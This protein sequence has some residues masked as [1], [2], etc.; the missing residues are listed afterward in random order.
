MGKTNFIILFFILTLST[1][2][3]SV[4]GLLK[5]P[6]DINDRSPIL[7]SDLLTSL[8]W[9]SL[10]KFS[11]TH[12]GHYTSIIKDSLLIK[13]EYI[14]QGR[15]TWFELESYKNMVLQFNC[16]ISNTSKPIN[17]DYFDKNVW[18]E[19]V[20]AMLPKLPEHFQLNANEPKEILK[21]YYRL[22]GA[23]KRDE[24]GW[25]CEYSTVGE[26]PGKRQAVIELLGR[27]DLL[28]KLFDYPNLQ[29]QLYAADALIFD[30]Y[31]TQRMIEKENAAN[32]KINI[33][34]LNSQLMTKSEWQK[35][36]KL[37]DSNQLVK[38]CGNMG[39]YKT[40]EATTSELLSEKSI[41]EIPEQYKMLKELGYFRDSFNNE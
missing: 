31:R 23:N 15:V 8:N 19:Y 25:I 11:T 14:E 1:N 33:E 26:A 7:T 2:A 39:S 34:Y 24:Y 29:T 5:F 40:Y 16:V 6:V 3:Q 37:R 36:Y 9:K 35:I 13:Y 30:N 17:I 38:I 41:T 18:I 20:T 10:E 22:L 28:W 32:S 27:K 4:F 12:D 21:A